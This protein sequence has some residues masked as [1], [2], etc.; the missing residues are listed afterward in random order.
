MNNYEKVFRI[1]GLIMLTLF[2]G[3]YF[4]KVNIIDL[5]ILLTIGLLI[6]AADT[7]GN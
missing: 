6:V 4:V 2:L 7:F 1:L 3:I 5:Q